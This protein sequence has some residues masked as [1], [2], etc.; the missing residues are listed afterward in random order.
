LI[1]LTIEDASNTF[2]ILF[3]SKALTSGFT[4]GFYSIYLE[5]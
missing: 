3:L 5:L 2:Y 1:F 4:V